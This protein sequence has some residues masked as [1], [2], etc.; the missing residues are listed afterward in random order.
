MKKNP[1]TVFSNL[2]TRY[3]KK[4]FDPNDKSYICGVIQDN[5]EYYYDQY[6]SCT[7]IVYRLSG[8]PDSIKVV[9]P[10][11]Y[12]KFYLDQSIQDEVI[13]VAGTYCSREY[14]DNSG[15]RHNETFLLARIYKIYSPNEG[16]ETTRNITYIN[17]FICKK[18]VFRLTPKG[19]EICDL[20][21]AV[22]T[23]SKA[24]YFHCVAWNGAA[25]YSRN[26]RVG[27][28]VEMFCRIQSRT[29]FKE[30]MNQYFE[31]NELS[32][33]TIRLV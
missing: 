11:S 10:Y 32:V 1:I 14:F 18:P 20:L 7:V 28:N 25:R 6:Y 13:E 33:Q 19:V 2:E 21:V 9:L 12:A 15:N 22:N 24:Y 27:S 3:G 26:L 4:I 8:I 5:L 31:I 17:G 30:S 23:Q 29:Y 16:I